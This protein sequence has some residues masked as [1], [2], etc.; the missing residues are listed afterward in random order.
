[1]RGLR[2]N[3]ASSITLVGVLAV[4]AAASS[5]APSQIVPSI[6]EVLGDIVDNVVQTDLRNAFLITLWRVLLG[7][8]S[9]FLIGLV[10]GLITGAFASVAAY[11]LP[12]IRFLQGIPSV[13]WVVLA[14]IWFSDIEIRVWFIMVMV[15]LPGFALQIHDSYR[16]IPED[17]RDMARSFRPGRKAMMTELVIP[18]VMPGIFTTWKVNLGLGIRVVLIAEL[19]G[20]TVGVGVQLLSAQQLFDMA[21]VVAWTLMLAITSLVVQGAMEILENWVLRYRPSPARRSSR[22]MAGDVA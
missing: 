15:T 11:L 14:V 6:G 4:W 21:A 2:F 13:S 8:V 18:G 12:L 16:A 10:I 19:V 1:V 3:P 22:V 5:F 7:L 17:L 9:A 20:A